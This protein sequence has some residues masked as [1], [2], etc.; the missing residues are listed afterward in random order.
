MPCPTGCITC[1]Y[2]LIFRATLPPLQALNCTECATGYV[3]NLFNGSCAPCTPNCLNCTSEGDGGTYTMCNVCAPG[4]SL[5]YGILPNTCSP[6]STVT[7]NL[8][9]TTE[10]TDSDT[11]TIIGLS[12]WGAV[13]TIAA[14]I[15]IF[16]WY[17]KSQE[18]KPVALLGSEANTK[19]V[20]F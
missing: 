9:N 12:V 15:L 2:G 10:N 5:N 3:I 4:Y 20:T 8:Q 17:R 16:L 11:S 7:S 1:Q 14:A 13:M 19:T 18:V 6:N